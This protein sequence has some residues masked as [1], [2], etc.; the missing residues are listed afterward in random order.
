MQVT[1][2]LL[3]RQLRILI[4]V[5]NILPGFLDHLFCSIITFCIHRLVYCNGS[6]K[7]PFCKI[8][9]FLGTGD[10]GKGLI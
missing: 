10:Q 1:A 5:H 8:F 3:H 9:L 2:D 6:L 4:V 7:K